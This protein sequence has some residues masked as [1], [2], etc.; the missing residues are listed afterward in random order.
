MFGLSEE[1]LDHEKFASRFLGERFDFPSPAWRV[2]LNMC[3]GYVEKNGVS[4]AKIEF[5]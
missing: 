5:G 2:E 1:A 4:D 3:P